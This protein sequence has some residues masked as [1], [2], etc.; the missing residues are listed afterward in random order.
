MI[1]ISKGEEVC[2]MFYILNVDPCGKIPK[3]II[4]I[5]APQ[6]G[7]NIKHFVDNIDKAKEMLHSREDHVGAPPLVR[8]HSNCER[9]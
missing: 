3:A 7:M 4:N 9:L 5:A 1:F 2:R 8:M 6:Q